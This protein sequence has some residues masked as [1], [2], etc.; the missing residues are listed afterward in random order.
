MDI[1]GGFVA[2]LPGS[3]NLSLISSFSH[4]LFVLHQNQLHEAIKSIEHN[5]GDRLANAS[6]DDSWR[7]C[8]HLFGQ[9]SSYIRSGLLNISAGWYPP[10]RTVGSR[11][12]RTPIAAD[13][14]FSISV[15]LLSQRRCSGLIRESISLTAR[16]MHGQYSPEYCPLFIRHSTIWEF[17]S[18]EA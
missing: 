11:F 8:S 10:G 9:D 14:Y 2:K 4:H 13:A 18:M 15:T 5:L 16:A 1:T 12:G 6:A 7:M 17:K 3:A